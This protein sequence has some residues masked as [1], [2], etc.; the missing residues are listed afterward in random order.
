MGRGNRSYQPDV[1]KLLSDVKASRQALKFI[2]KV[3]D[4]SPMASA[5]LRRYSQSYFAGQEDGKAL[6]AA[7]LEGKSHFADWINGMD[8]A[9]TGWVLEKDIL[10]W[11]GWTISPPRKYQ[12]FMSCTLVERMARKFGAHI[13]TAILVKAGTQVAVPMK[14]WNEND[15]RRTIG[16]VDREVEIVLGRNYT[17]EDIGVVSPEWSRRSVRILTARSS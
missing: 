3:K 6:N 9:C 5:A 17:L 10:L 16:V 14:V 11:R 13:L 7:I 15:D 1:R 4:L 12:A 8:D 2:S